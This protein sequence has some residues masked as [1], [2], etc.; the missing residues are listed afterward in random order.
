LKFD[1]I[2]INSSHVF[3]ER[4]FSTPNWHLLYLEKLRINPYEWFGQVS[5]AQRE[6]LPRRG[7]VR[8]RVSQEWLYENYVPW[9]KQFFPS[10]KILNMN[11][12]LNKLHD[13]G[14]VV[15]KNRQRLH[16]KTRRVVD[17]NYL[18]F[19]TSWNDRYNDEA[20]VWCTEE[21]GELKIIRKDID[22]YISDE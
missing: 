21:A 13:I 5:V 3:I 10:S 11:T 12:F 6:R 19:F 9:M 16:N 14:L 1:S 8:I 17:L 4:F 18:L 22:A 20:T 7:E 15:H 2:N